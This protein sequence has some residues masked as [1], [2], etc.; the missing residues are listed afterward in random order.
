[1]LK[2]REAAESALRESEERFRAVVAA[3]EEGIVIHEVDGSISSCN[4]SACR[5]LGLQEEQILGRTSRNPAWRAVREDGSPFEP[6]S[7]PA[8]ITLL[9]GLACSKVTMG[10]ERRDGTLAWISL[11]S[12]PLCRPGDSDPYAVAVSFSDITHL[13]G[14]EREMRRRAEQQSVVADVAQHALGGTPVQQL[15]D[16]AVR[17]IADVLDLAR[18]GV[19]DRLKLHLRAGTGF[20]DEFPMGADH[21]SACTVLIPGRHRSWGFLLAHPRPGAR[22]G[23]EDVRFLESVATL[24]GVAAERDREQSARRRTE[25]RQERLQHGLRTSA[26]EWRLTFDAITHPLLLVELGG[27]IIRLNRAARDLSGVD[28]DRAVY[29]PIGVLGNGHPWR[30]IREMLPQVEGDVLSAQARD[31]QGRSWDI[32]MSP[33][34]S[35]DDQRGVVVVARDITDLVRLQESVR[36][37]ETMSAMGGLVAGVAHEVRNPLFGISATLD[38]FESRFGKRKDFRRYFDVLQ[39]EVKRLSELMHQLLDYGKPAR[40]DFADVTPDEVM[41]MASTA[42]A[43]LA[44]RSEVDLVVQSDEG[45]PRLQVDRGRI[46]QVFQNLLENAIQHSPRGRTVVIR[47]EKEDGE[48]EGVRFAVEDT[49]PGFLPGDLHRVFEPFFTRRRGGTGLGLSIV[50]RIVEQHGGDVAASNRTS[51]GAAMTVFLPL[52]PRRAGAP[53]PPA[54]A[55]VAGR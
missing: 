38:A 11:N 8:T 25:A 53:G 2:T 36:R 52:R 16:K 27:R 39:G 6:E 49:G 24:L 23:A 15:L 54:L 44:S 40:L 26:Q 46:A 4:A 35:P 9:T 37:S 5:I 34:T 17:R 19:T 30:A 42:C 22:L 20:G 18:C 47:A 33:V 28:Y 3:L 29:H 43:P 50:Q 45:L 12:R 55:E 21:P 41:A 7:Q 48:R 10:I 13:K 51:G 1:M 14:A 32:S 31:D